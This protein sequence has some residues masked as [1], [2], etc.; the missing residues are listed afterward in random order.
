MCAWVGSDI[1]LRWLLVAVSLCSVSVVSVCVCRFGSDIGLR[2]WGV[3]VAVSLC[4]VAVVCVCIVSLCSVVCA[5]VGLDQ[6]SGLIGY[7]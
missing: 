3:L 1:G 4:S 5:C 2:R 6:I 7:L